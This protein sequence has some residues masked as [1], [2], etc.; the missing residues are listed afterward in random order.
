MSA[1]SPCA[2]WE[3]ISGEIKLGVPHIV[4][5]FSLACSNLVAN[6]KSAIFT[7]ILDVRSILP[8]LKS[9]CKIWCRRRKRRRM[10]RRMRRKRK[11]RTGRKERMDWGLLSSYIPDARRIL[12][13]DGQGF[14]T[15]FDHSHQNTLSPGKKCS[16]AKKQS[17]TGSCIR[18]GCVGCFPP[19]L[20]ISCNILHH[21]NEK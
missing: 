17:C 5:C 19:H 15:S 20:V 21:S 12:Q 13:S 4:K 14:K 10:R 11:K 1:S 8:R 18:G 16:I 3:T 2:D 6:P 9:R 7:S